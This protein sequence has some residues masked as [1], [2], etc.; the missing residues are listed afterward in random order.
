MERVNSELLTLAAK[1]NRLASQLSQKDK[2]YRSAGRLARDPHDVDA[3][4]AGIVCLA[5][6]K[7]RPLVEWA[8]NPD[9]FL[10]LQFAMQQVSFGYWEDLWD[11]VHPDKVGQAWEGED[12]ALMS[13]WRKKAR[14]LVKE[15]RQNSI[16]DMTTDEYVSR[17]IELGCNEEV[18]EYLAD[19]QA[20][21][22]YDE[23]EPSA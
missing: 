14:I 16:L 20:E 12:F 13:V 6:S 23:I 11:E 2:M 5:K 3:L 21:I 19:W 9:N 4:S 10:L 8:R 22:S 15:C 18:I 17:L 1:A 7:H